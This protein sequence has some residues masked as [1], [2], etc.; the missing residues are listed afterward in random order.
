[1][2]RKFIGKL[3]D[4][5][6]SG[7]KVTENE[8]YRLSQVSDD[9][10]LLLLDSATRI[11][12]KYKRTILDVCSLLNAKSGLCA[13]DC[14]Y[15][16]QSTKYK[17]DVPAY[18]LVSMDKMVLS[19]MNAEKMHSG[20]FCIVTSGGK[21]NGKELKTI[22][23]GY[24]RIRKKIRIKLDASLGILS[25]EELKLLKKHGVS[26]YN[27]NLETAESYY[28]KICTT[29]KF[30]DR[31]KTIRNCKKAGLEVCSGGILGM[32]E[33][34][35]QR[36]ELAFT[37]KELDVDLVP[38]NFLNPIKGTPLQNRKPLLP[39]EILKIIVVFRF[40]LPDKDIKICGGRETNLRSLQPLLFYAG[41]NGIIIGNYLTT[42]GQDYQKDLQMIKDIGLKLKK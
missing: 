16:S 8:M 20:R 34:W 41:A 30:A 26:R 15:C 11:A 36:I 42:T 19:A 10:L 22:C 32:G 35:K 13:E 5:V 31:V 21:V 28:L 9:N 7:K 1:M 24:D 3:A 37:L 33:S 18:P 6:L 12:K 39:V 27:H 23:D 38:L 40:I 2:E 29:H 17:T 25:L 4:K 14:K